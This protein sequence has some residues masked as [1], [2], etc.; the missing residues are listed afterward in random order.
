M[1]N[2]QDK[3]DPTKAREDVGKK[4]EELFKKGEEAFKKSDEVLRRER[5]HMAE[6]GRKADEPR[7]EREGAGTPGKEEKPTD[8]GQGSG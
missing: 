1:S 6:T 2:T 3:Y 7:Q 8:T 5:E 4:G